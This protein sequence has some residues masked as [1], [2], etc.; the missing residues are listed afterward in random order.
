MTSGFKTVF[1]QDVFQAP[2]NFSHARVLDNG[3][4]YAS[5]QIPLDTEGKIVGT[6]IE[7]QTEQVLKNHEAIL[8]AAGSSLKNILRINVY[9]VEPS[10]YSG[11]SDIYSKMIP[12]PK[13]PRGCIFVNALPAGAK[14]EMDLVAIVGA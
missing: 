5:A 13:P 10:D 4:V 8:I 7:K 14:V 2:A 1:S 11:F 3:L 9:L 12:D 6:T